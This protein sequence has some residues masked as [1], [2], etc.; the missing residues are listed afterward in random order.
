MK[1]NK[2]EEGVPRV[3]DRKGMWNL[4][5]FPGCSNFQELGS[6]QLT[7]NLLGFSGDLIPKA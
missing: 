6:I 2:K 4:R 7:G 3:R 1:A 5:V